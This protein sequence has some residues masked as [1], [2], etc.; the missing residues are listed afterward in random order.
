M[1]ECSLGKHL[2]EECH[3]CSYSKT[4][5]YSNKV[6]TDDEKYLLS[7]RTNASVSSL[8]DI[9]SFHCQ[10]YITYYSREQ[11]YCCDPLKKHDKKQYRKGRLIEISVAFSKENPLDLIPGQKLC[12]RCKETLIKRSKISSLEG[13]FSE[14]SMGTDEDICADKTASEINE[15]LSSICG[16]ISPISSNKL[17][18]EQVKRKL[19]LKA[20]QVKEKIMK[21]GNLDDSPQVSS[22]PSKEEEYFNELMS[23]VK[24]RL[25]EENSSSEK[26]KLLTLAPRHWTIEK[27]ATFFN[28]SH[29]MI[30]EARK[31]VKEK[32]ILSSKDLHSVGTALQQSTKDL[33]GDFYESNEHTRILPGKKD[34]V[35]VRTVQGKEQKQKMLLLCNL[36]EL[37]SIFKTKYPDLKVGF[38]SFA[39]LRP[40]WCVLAGSAGTHTVCVCTYHENVKL[41]LT[42]LSRDLDYKELMA[43]AVC[44]LKSK[45][46]MFHTCKNCP[47][48]ETLKKR[49]EAYI[50]D[51]NSVT[52]KQWVTVDRS[53]LTMMTEDADD[54]IENLCNDIWDLTLHECIRQKQSAFLSQLKMSL[55]NNNIIIIGDFAE[56]YKCIIQDSIQSAYFSSVQIT[57]HPFVMYYDTPEGLSSKS[58]CIVSN[59]LVHS[60]V[61]VHCFI[62][63]LIP[64]I[65]ASLPDLHHIY[66]F[67]DG[68]AAQYKNR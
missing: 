16:S 58:F 11:R 47:G 13:Q 33:I 59:S 57:L 6:L 35:S 48:L 54:F 24:V 21:I 36:K 43:E 51:I 9:C 15:E 2:Q 29:Y 41:K 50:E 20:D 26:V 3:K 4:V 55:P 23:A 60:H 61:S 49:L 17:S 18:R 28:V 14:E 42:G 44:D 32:G 64:L 66:Y 8:T 31:L 40:K 22:L 7:K 5:E 56:N 39:S 30:K 37:Y 27:C 68:S 34:C 25:Q 19:K 45:D 46:C 65:K 1:D 63:A 10:K 67:T 62:S 12:Y 53:E 38:S 52:Y